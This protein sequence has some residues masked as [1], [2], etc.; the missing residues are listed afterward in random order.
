MIC[1]ECSKRDECKDLC[2]DVKKLVKQEVYEKAKRD[3]IMLIPNHGMH[4]FSNFGD[5]AFLDHLTEDD[6]IKFSTDA[7]QLNMTKIFIER[8]FNKRSIKDIADQLGCPENTVATHY[9]HAV[10]KIMEMVALLELRNEGIK[11][12]RKRRYTPGQEAFLL[13]N[14]FG[15]TGEDVARI[16][17]VA[18]STVSKCLTRME[19]R[20]NQVLEVAGI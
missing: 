14:I 9:K 7:I 20:C 16:R 13:I 4:C 2:P 3:H 18:K 6:A 12:V 10:D 17:G 1:R 11:A 19:R 8:F 5:A 15:F